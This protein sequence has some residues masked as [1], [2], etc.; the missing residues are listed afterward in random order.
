[1][2]AALCIPAAWAGADAPVA[3]P[4]GTALTFVSDATVDPRTVHPG[5]RFRVHLQT[6]LRLG[7][8][9]LAAASTPAD[10]VVVAVVRMPTP[11]LRIALE[12]FV[13]PGIGDVPLRAATP[14]VD[15]IDA[16]GTVAATTAGVVDLVAGRAVIRVPLPFP[17]TGDP[18]N[19]PFRAQ[20]ARTTEPV[21]RP[22]RPGDPPAAAPSPT[23][24]D[25]T[26]PELQIP[27]VSPSPTTTPS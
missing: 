11:G 18:P 4:S 23:P 26:P 24:V 2:G 20:P 17:L 15:R 5:N 6:D 27:A 12:R 3:L 10:L 25:T 1:M 9:L 21:L 7:P 16:G 13:L 14:E 22:R 8:V 19:A